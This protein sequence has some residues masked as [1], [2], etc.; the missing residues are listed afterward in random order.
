MSYFH[1]L[2]QR[3]AKQV[4]NGMSIRTFWGERV[5][6]SVVDLEPGAEVPL[7][8][9]AH[10]QAGMVLVGTAEFTI[11][12]ETRTLGAGDLYVIPGGVEHGLKVGSGPCRALDIFSPVREEYKY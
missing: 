3:A 8:T 10:E 7:H 11:G 4:M 1:Q 12:G 5:L 2:D 6:L 9:H